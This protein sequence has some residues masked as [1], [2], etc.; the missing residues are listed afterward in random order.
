MDLNAG[1]PAAPLGDQSGQKKQPVLV[2]PMGDPV[3]DNGMH[4]GIQQKDLQF[5]AGC[6]ITSLIGRQGFIQSFE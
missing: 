6:R 2:K 4:T 1:L 3:I 5:A